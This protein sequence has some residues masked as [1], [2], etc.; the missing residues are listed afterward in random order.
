MLLGLWCTTAAYNVVRC[1][2]MLLGLCRAV[3]LQD[4]GGVKQVVPQVVS[5]E[6]LGPAAGRTGR[7][8]AG[9]SA[10]GEYVS[11]CWPAS[12]AYVVHYRTLA[13]TWQ[14]VDSGLAVDLAWHS[15]R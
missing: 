4:M 15:T 8:I 5:Q 14:Q 3:H 10:T 1:C 13:G 12:R 6:P 9:V 7:A 2:C 11:V